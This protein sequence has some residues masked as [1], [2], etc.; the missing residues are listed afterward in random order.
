[1]DRPLPKAPTHQGRSHCCVTAVGTRSRRTDRRRDIHT[2]PGG[3]LEALVGRSDRPRSSPQQL[4]PAVECG[5]SSCAAFVSGRRRPLR[6]A[7]AVLNQKYCPQPFIPR[8]AVPHRRNHRETGAEPREAAP[9]GECSPCDSR[10]SLVALEWSAADGPGQPG[11]T[12]AVP[13]NVSRPSQRCQRG[14]LPPEDVGPPGT[15]TSRE[16]SG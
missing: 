16:A 2:C 1:M 8:D 11:P 12:T 6:A 5:R 15:E 3:G 9:P 13:T 7:E 4:H 14:D 10:V